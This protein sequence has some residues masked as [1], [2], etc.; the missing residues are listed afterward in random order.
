MMMLMI[1]LTPKDDNEDTYIETNN[2]N[3]ISDNEAEPTED[4]TAEDETEAIPDVENDPAVE[5]IQEQRSEEQ[6]NE[7]T[8]SHKYNLRKNKKT[9]LL[10]FFQSTQL[11]FQHDKK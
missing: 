1:K 7:E 6:R 2:E 9:N 4:S 8:I 5:N 3:T 10:Q 11:S